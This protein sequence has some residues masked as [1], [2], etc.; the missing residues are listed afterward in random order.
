M[1]AVPLPDAI[2]KRFANKTILITGYESDQVQKTP[3]VTLSSLKKSQKLKKVEGDKSW[4][5]NL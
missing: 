4:P 5:I 3:E 2:V 1:D